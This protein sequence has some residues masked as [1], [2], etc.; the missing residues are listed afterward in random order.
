MYIILKPAV[1]LPTCRL[2]GYFTKFMLGLF[3]VLLIPFWFLFMWIRQ[4]ALPVL[5][6]VRHIDRWGVQR[7]YRTSAALGPYW[8]GSWSA[9]DNIQVDADGKCI[10]TAKSITEAIHSIVGLQYIQDIAYNRQVKLAMKFPERT[11][12]GP[13]R[14]AGENR[15]FTSFYNFL[16]GRKNNKK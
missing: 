4:N 10:C 15:E 7:C 8:W 12:C 16:Y 3:S 5:V 11:M 14:V 6:A 13:P 2:H 9:V 1:V